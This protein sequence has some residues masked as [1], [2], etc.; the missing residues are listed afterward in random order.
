MGPRAPHKHRCSFRLPVRA[1]WLEWKLLLL[2]GTAL[3]SQ[4]K[5]K[6]WWGDKQAGHRDLFV[7]N[8]KECQLPSAFSVDWQGDS[9]RQSQCTAALQMA[10]ETPGPRLSQSTSNVILGPW[11]NHLPCTLRHWIQLPPSCY[12]SGVWSFSVT[13]FRTEGKNTY[14]EV[15]VSPS[16][17]D[18]L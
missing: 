3:W 15:R 5:E 14:P 16:L 7:W 9:K 4:Q 2:K 17:A 1:W 11:Q 12:T 18:K 13:A 8:F 6:K 10:H